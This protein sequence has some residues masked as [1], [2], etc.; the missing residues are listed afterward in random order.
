MRA[1]QCGLLVV[2]CGPRLAKPGNER[3]RG[4]FLKMGAEPDDY[5]LYFISSESRF[6]LYGLF[7]L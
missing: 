2:K 5:S 6:V 3:V 7:L 1:G 4:Y